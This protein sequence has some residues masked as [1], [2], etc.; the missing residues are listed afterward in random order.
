MPRLL[1][2]ILTI[3]LITAE[4]S[5]GPLV[6]P[7]WPPKS[8][9][10]KPMLYHQIASQPS[11]AQQNRLQSLYQ[12][13]LSPSAVSRFPSSSSLLQSPSNM[14]YTQSKHRQ[15]YQTHTQPPQKQ[16]QS[17]PH[18]PKRI[19]M[20]QQSPKLHASPI[21]GSSPYIMMSSVKPHHHTS[22]QHPIGSESHNIYFKQPQSS[23]SKQIVSGLKHSQHKTVDY[24]FENPFATNNEGLSLSSIPTVGGGGPYYFQNPT[25]N[26]HTI[27]QL[28][29]NHLVLP[30]STSTLLPIGGQQ[31]QQTQHYRLQ[32]NAYNKPQPHVQQNTKPKYNPIHTI[33]APDLTLL[34]QK[35]LSNYI[36]RPIEINHISEK[37]LLVGAYNS[38]QRPYSVS[39]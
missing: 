29:G 24:V 35:P 32:P 5:N 36:N 16:I 19:V 8:S 9:Q 15:Q 11:P 30:S 12:M 26:S 22:A 18:Q 31:T 28:K 6:Y 14:I 21:S 7:S 34:E 27:F 38:Q 1:S 33:T 3:G 2:F 23:S 39:R 37:D 20:R 25:L 10:P 17:Q 4:V 13:R